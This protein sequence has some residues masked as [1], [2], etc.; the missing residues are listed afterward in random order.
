MYELQLK[1]IKERPILFSGPMV[2]A[3]LEGR[4]TQTRR[5][6]VPQPVPSKVF[7]GQ[8]RWKRLCR[9]MD[10]LALS[11]PYGKPGDRLWVRETWAQIY[12][13]GDYCIRD[14]GEFFQCPCDGCR[15]EYRADTGNPY[16]GEWPEDMAKEDDEAPRWR[17]SIHMPRWASRLTVELVNVRAE[18]LQDISEE[19]AAAEGVAF[20]KYLNANARFHFKELW[21][22]IN[23]KRGYSW[24]SNPWVWVLD[25]ERT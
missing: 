20:T 21:D 25:F 6:M 23:A 11:C 19:D 9:P 13:T 10:E 5:V 22:S 18:R 7:A 8:M 1:T 24:D 17:P 14:E 3:I 2:K 16:P 12:R 4:K 15:V